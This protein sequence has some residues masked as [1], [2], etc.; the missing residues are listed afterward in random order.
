MYHLK[1]LP[2]VLLFSIVP[3]MVMAA[4]LKLA[5]PEHYAPLVWTE[6]GKMKGA[7][8]DLLNIIFRN[9]LDVETQYN[10]YPW[11]RAQ[12]NVEK[13]IA[14]AFVTTP[15][16]ERLTYTTCSTEPVFDIDIV[17][18]TYLNHPRRDEILAV[19][20]PRDLLKFILVDYRG[21]GWLKSRLPD[22]RVV[23]TDTLEQTYK[24]LA[25]KRADIIVR[26]TVNFDY[27]ARDHRYT[28]RIEKTSVVVD[29]INIHLCINKTSEYT[30]ILPDFDRVVRELRKEGVIESIVK[31]YTHPSIAL[32]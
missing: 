12:I 20:T 30:S 24:L 28:D 18:Y 11:S 5:F 8:I 26:D 19:S 25:N 6:N 1:L 14:D 9:K 15:T 3:A 29:T 13:G 17:I 4:P 21:N 7:A 10:G 16:P 32:N 22:A 27:H 23:W 31:D 2:L